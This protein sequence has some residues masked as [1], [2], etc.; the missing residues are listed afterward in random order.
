M[1][2]KH[3]LTAS[4]ARRALA[5]ALLVTFTFLAACSGSSPTEPD[6]PIS[7]DSV[8]ATS[9]SLVNGARGQNGKGALAFDPVL[10]EIARTYS[11]QM[12]DQGFVSH[13]DAAGTAVDGRL[14]SYGVH[15]TMAGEN[16]ATLG[17]T[18]DPAGE[19]HRGFMASAS[20]RANILQPGFTS[21]GVGVATNGDQYWLTQVFIRE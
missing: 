19:A 16:I 12:R 18:T 21:V 4:P 7:I 14:R 2:P 6:G 10:C 9:V 13:Y 20:H 5:A 1:T 11:R 17:D 8:E 3:S 15:F